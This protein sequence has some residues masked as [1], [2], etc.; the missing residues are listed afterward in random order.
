MIINID[1]TKSLKRIIIEFNDEETT[2]EIDIVKKP[3][4]KIKKST[5]NK[6]TV[7]NDEE[8]QSDN[9]SDKTLDLSFLNNNSNNEKKEIVEK[10]SIPDIENRTAEIADSMQNLEF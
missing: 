7:L 1:E 8:N 4:N 9:I 10:P 2:E 5:P 6:K 3:E